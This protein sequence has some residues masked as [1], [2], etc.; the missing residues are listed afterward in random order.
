VPVLKFWLKTIDT[1][2]HQ[3]EETRF[4]SVRV[5]PVDKANNPNKQYITKDEYT[6][7][8]GVFVKEYGHIAR[9][10][11][12]EEYDPPAMT[13]RKAVTRSARCALIMYNQHKMRNLAV[14]EKI[15]YPVEQM[16]VTSLRYSS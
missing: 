9:M 8:K 1:K 13:R 3:K 11:R 7:Y 4:G 14:P 15:E 10:G 6:I 12:A 16:L 5:K 2:I